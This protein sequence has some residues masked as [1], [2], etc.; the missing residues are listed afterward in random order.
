MKGEF[1]KIARS[2]VSLNNFIPQFKELQRS[3]KM[4]GFKGRKAINPLKK[5]ILAHPQ[6]VQQFSFS[7]QNLSLNYLL[8]NFNK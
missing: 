4:K 5:M 2:A 1:A 6:N 3:I 7:Y 8:M